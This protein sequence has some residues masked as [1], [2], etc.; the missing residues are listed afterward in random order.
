MTRGRPTG[1]SPPAL[2]REPLPPEDVNV[3][4]PAADAIT[5]R[6]L[7]GPR[8]V[9]VTAMLDTGAA[10][11]I[12][13]KA[14]LQK[15]APDEIMGTAPRPLRTVS[16]EQLPVRGTV[17]LATAVAGLGRQAEAKHTWRV[18][19][20]LSNDW[21]VVVGLDLMR[22]LRFTVDTVRRVPMQLDGDPVAAAV[23]MEALVA[24]TALN[25]ETVAVVEAGETEAAGAGASSAA[26]L[27]D[28]PAF[29]GPPLLR[30]PGLEPE[31]LPVDV[32]LRGSTLEPAKREE[33]RMLLVEYADVFAEA[34]QAPWV[35]NP[36]HGVF[37]G[38]PTGTAAPIR[39]P[40]YRVSAAE[41][42]ILRRLVD[43][44]EAA[45]IVRPSCSPWAAPVVLVRRKDGKHRFCVD[46]RR[47]N[48]VT[49]KDA[50]PM[51]LVEDLVDAL[52]GADTF[53][54]LDLSS[55]YW[56]IPVAPEDIPKTAFVTPFGLYEFVVMPFGLTSAPATFQRL[57]NAVLRHLP[58]RAYLD[59]I[60]VGSTH[61]GRL[62]ALFQ[63]L[64]AAGLRL[65]ASKCHVGQPSIKFLGRVVSKDGLGVD[66]DKT[67]AIDAWPRPKDATGVRRF[68]GLA[69]YYRRFVDRF[70]E[71]AEPLTRLTGTLA[72][73]EWDDAHETAFQ[74]LKA[75]LVS[76][77]VLVLPLPGLPFGLITDASTVGI[78]AILTQPRPGDA[79]AEPVIAYASRALID[80]ERRYSAT[81]LECLAVVWGLEKF[82]VYTWGQP[83]RVIT[84]HQALQ[85]LWSLKAP[86]GRL[87]RW[88]L[89]LQ[90]F[91][92]TVAYRPGRLNGSADALSREL[93][94]MADG[95]GD[96]S[97]PVVA[98]TD[99][100]PGTAVALRDAQARDAVVGPLRA[101]LLDGQLPSTVDDAARVVATAAALELDEHGRVV[102]RASARH[103]QPERLYVPTELR[104]RCSRRTMTSA[105]AATSRPPRR[106]AASRSTTTGRRSARTSARTSRAAS[107]AR[108][109]RRP[110]RP[111]RASSCR[112]RS[113][114][115]GS[116]SPSTCSA[117]CQRRSAATATSS[118]SP[119]RAPSGSRRSRRSGRT[120]TRW[121]G[122]SG[123]RSSAATARPRGCCPIRDLRSSRSSSRRSP[124]RPAS[125]RSA[126]RPTTR[127]P[128]ARWSASTTRSR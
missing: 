118:S 70:A 43:E 115:P 16:G 21:D 31:V 12:I 71:I 32:M 104:P 20:A 33:L 64:R 7:L 73:F 54:S 60:A 81:E 111:R 8:R 114:G 127:R 108:R 51:A 2:P 34:L 47:L 95:D 66:D 19:D 10:V 82:R 59:D 79:G 38:I 46:Y 109:A 68:L 124:A 65:K 110:A 25:W 55:G 63:V 83:V 86:T 72:A 11:S 122:C 88:A 94:G 18:V 37:H 77:P 101:Y 35:L 89:R 5:T 45:G 36:A 76:A 61:V 74:Q 27:A 90:E 42:D 40:P 116:A 9:A 87:G 44:M 53:T 4:A 75:A 92:I 57:M 49:V 41:R 113:W 97:A 6:L 14:C 102:L 28:H 85:W 93:L 117:R 107:T 103:G 52:S 22:H 30:A 91:D 105:S 98:A 3:P 106:S 126:R 50:F 1:S 67:R 84:D 62:R 26:Y 23:V 99:V 78:S 48:A 15:T 80:A 121:H 13:S 56:Q 125:T 96:P 17:S 69:S 119:T 24:S 58:E 29:E 128:T 120:P 112:C 39:L 100:D 123:T